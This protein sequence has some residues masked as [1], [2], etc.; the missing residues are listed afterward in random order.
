MIIIQ[1]NHYK[2][3]ILM[4]IFLFISFIFHSALSYIKILF[5]LITDYYS[6]QIKSISIP[7][8]MNSD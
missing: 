7:I 1:I 8:H 4:N 3:L 6:Q 2:T 5:Y